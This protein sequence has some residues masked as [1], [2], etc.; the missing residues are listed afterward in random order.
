MKVSPLVLLS[1]SIVI[2]L[3]IRYVLTDSIDGFADGAG[4]T[5]YIIKAEWC[6]HC[7]KAMPE[8]KKLV[9][10]SPLSLGSGEKVEIKMLDGDSDKEAIDAMG[11]KVRGF[12]TMVLKKG[13]S[14]TEYPGERT[15]E[16]VKAFL[17]Q[18]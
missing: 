2:L 18:L 5:F 8:F 11:Y 4:S 9:D 1:A 6:G 10:A 3:V 15:E 12:P 17:E 16:G 7:K 13:G 14:F